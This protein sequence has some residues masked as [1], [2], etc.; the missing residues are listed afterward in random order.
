MRNSNRNIFAIALIF[1]GVILVLQNFNIPLFE[2]FNIGSFIGIIWPLFILIPGLN[3]LKRK[4]DFGGIILTVLG[5]AFL[6]DNA[7]KLIGIDFHATSIFKFFWPAVLIYLGYKL[8]VSSDHKTY[9]NSK[10]VNF[11]DYP[12]T[13]YNE[14]PVSLAFNAK[15]FKYTRENLSQGISTLNLNITFGGAEIIVEEGIQV[16]LVGQY[17]MGGHEFFGQDE[18]GF[19]SEIKEVRY[20]ETDEDF[21]DQTLIIKANITFGGLEIY[22][23]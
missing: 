19:H 4:V 11:D 15:K 3:M 5:S 12:E 7:L 6:L 23:L 2:S 22:S 9:K 21:Y 14:K 1:I 18:G 17:S 10:H 13:N 8:L 16:I 20:P